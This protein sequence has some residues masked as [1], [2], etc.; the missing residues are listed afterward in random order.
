MWNPINKFVRAN[1]VAAAFLLTL[2]FTL[3]SAA[4]GFPTMRGGME[5][6][7]GMPVFTVYQAALAVLGIWLMC[8]LRVRA[9]D[10]FKCKNIGRGFLLGWVMFA[11]MTV[12]VLTSY[13]NRSDYFIK[14]DPLFLLTV[15]LFPFSTGLLE[16]VVFRGIV[17]KILLQK[18]GGAKK[19]IINAFLVSAALFAAVHSIHLFWA[20]PLD[21]T[22]DLLLAVAGGVFMGSIYL[23]TKTLIPSILLHGLFNLAGGIF[24]A[25]TG[26]EYTISPTTLADVAI[27][28]LIGAIPL[29]VAAFV[30]LR[31][32][33]PEDVSCI[34]SGSA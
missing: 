20:A 2:L 26:P 24:T 9:G 28:A 33:G 27:L 5:P 34:S 10:D 14:P 13:A 7:I 23:R 8:K 25:F 29:L 30:L 1:T 11:L 17:L 6:K 31:K 3:L 12:I 16:E 18:M 22:V 32:V 21:V 19:G 15:I 4:V